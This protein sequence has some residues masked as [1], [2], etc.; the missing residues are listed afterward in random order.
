MAAKAVDSAT[1]GVVKQNL[2]ANKKRG[3]KTSVCRLKA[4]EMTAERAY[5][6][7]LTRKRK[8][9]AGVAGVFVAGR[10]RGINQMASENQ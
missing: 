2:S 10:D 3:G 8:E 5:G 6:N 1:S 9:Q 4:G 7:D